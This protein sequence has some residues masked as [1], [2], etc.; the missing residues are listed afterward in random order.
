MPLITDTWADPLKEFDKFVFIYVFSIRNCFIIL[1]QHVTYLGILWIIYQYFRCIHVFQISWMFL[2]V[3]ISIHYLPILWNP[4]ILT[5]FIFMT[6]IVL[7]IQTNLTFLFVLNYIFFVEF[8]CNNFNF[9]IIKLFITQHY[10]L[11][12]YDGYYHR[13]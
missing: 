7:S 6:N 10:Y 4:D 3:M 2:F 5:L 8:P 1:K 9:S 12:P 11:H 13:S